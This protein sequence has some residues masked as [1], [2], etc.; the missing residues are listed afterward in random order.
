M[1][2]PA[3]LTMVEST[4]SMTSAA[5]T[6]ASTIQRAANGVAA[7]GRVADGVADGVAPDGVAG[8]PVT[9]PFSM[10]GPMAVGALMPVL[11]G[12]AGDGEVEDESLGGRTLFATNT[13]RYER[14]SCQE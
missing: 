1:V 8:P 13:V 14:S 9:G 6:T 12:L 3:T 5:S 7:G 10:S 11:S 2:G 4:R